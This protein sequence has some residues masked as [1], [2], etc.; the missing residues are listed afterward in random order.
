MTRGPRPRYRRACWYPVAFGPALA[1]RRSSRMDLRDMQ[2]AEVPLLHQTVGE[3]TPQD[4]ALLVEIR[5][6]PV[7][8]PDD[9]RVCGQLGEVA[10]DRHLPLPPD[11]VALHRRERAGSQKVPV[12]RG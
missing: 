12:E 6:D 3:L 5:I 2:V 8:E 11:V 10:G 9:R 1:A 4:G 7:A